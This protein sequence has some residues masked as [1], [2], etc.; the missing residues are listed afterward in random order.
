MFIV[1]I[2]IKGILKTRKKAEYCDIE[3]I[4]HQVKC[5]EIYTMKGETLIP[6]LT[7]VRVRARAK[8]ISTIETISMSAIDTLTASAEESRA[9]RNETFRASATS[10]SLS[11]VCL[12]MP[13][14]L[15]ETK[16]T[17]K[18]KNKC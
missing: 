18:G 2:M 10:G 7:F 8:A 13:T 14:S 12:L 9:W 15:N 17:V 6:E 16:T 11:I 3:Y 1:E 5:Y 4:S